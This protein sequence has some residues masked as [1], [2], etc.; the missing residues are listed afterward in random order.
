MQQTDRRTDIKKDQKKLCY[1]DWKPLS[2]EWMAVFEDYKVVV[3]L[4]FY[5]IYN[6]IYK[7]LKR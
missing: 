2:G 7:S 5:T 3:S 1:F 4:V 6:F